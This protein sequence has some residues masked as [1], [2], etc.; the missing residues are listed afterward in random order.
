MV[1]FPDTS[2]A[3]MILKLLTSAINRK[4]FLMSASLKSRDTF[5]PVY[6]LSK[7]PSSAGLV[8]AGG[9]TGFSSALGT[10]FSSFFTS[11]RGFSSA[12]LTSSLASSLASTLA[13]TLTSSFF[14]GGT[15]SNFVTT[16]FGFSI[17]KK[18]VLPSLVV[19]YGVSSLNLTNILMSFFTFLISILFT[20]LSN[21]F[22]F[23]PL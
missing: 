9:G 10:T 19:S 6:I 13:S 3:V 14:G 5:L 1:I 12:F 11:T 7:T 21:S 4:M 16:F 23:I 18:R 2:S 20:A 8:T 15:A 17:S 22:V